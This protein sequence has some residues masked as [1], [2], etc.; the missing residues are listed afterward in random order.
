MEI[1]L[2]QLLSYF[3]ALAANERTATILENRKKS[4]DKALADEK[5]LQDALV[6]A[7][8]LR[9][10][11]GRT[12]DELV[13]TRARLG[14]SANEEAL[15]QLLADDVFRA[16]IAEWFMAGGIEE[17]APV[18]KR[19]ITQME[20][21]LH[22][23]GASA[24]LIASLEDQYFDELDRA[25]FENPVLARWRHQLSLEYLRAQ[26]TELRRLAEEAAGLYSPEKQQAALDRYCEK[27]LAAW[28]I[29]DLS[30]LPE[31]DIDITTQTLLLR[32]LYMPLRIEVEQRA[33]S[34]YSEA[35]LARIEEDR[36][37][38]RRR[39][40]GH[41]PA[42]D[43]R[44]KRRRRT[45]VGERLA[46]ARCLVVLGDPGGGKTTMLRW[47]ATAYLLRYRNDEAFD[48]FP[49]ARPC[50]AGAGYRS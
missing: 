45:S 35:A 23:A 30:N 44:R 20:A 47:M 49:D 2:F 38:R 12:C 33:G 22:A 36:D 31:R 43:K 15:W 27:A 7:K 8:P 29:I 39:E 28:D 11:I 25:F 42:G 24:D 40:A 13:R 10:E 9:D 6:S 1:I 19:I 3:I 32:Q 48:Q 5:A 21:R 14:L 50:P 26:V 4:L 16:D 18:K 46:A 37:A 17:G 34:S 41:L